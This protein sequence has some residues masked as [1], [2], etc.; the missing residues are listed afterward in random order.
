MFTDRLSI[1]AHAATGLK[2][3]A[4]NTNSAHLAATICLWIGRL[5]AACLLLFWGGFFVEH[6]REWFLRADGQYPPL[7]VWIGQALHFGMLLGLA[8]SLKWE[9]LGA[10][11]TVVATAVFFAHIGGRGFPFLA[12]MNLAPIVFFAAWWMSRKQRSSGLQPA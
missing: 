1:W 6:L 8:I 12:L 3:G 7:K 4:V 5:V 9:K 2:V 11:L 10:L